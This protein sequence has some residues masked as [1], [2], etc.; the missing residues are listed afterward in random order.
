MK[1][2]TS[3]NLVNFTDSVVKTLPLPEGRDEYVYRDSVQTGLVLRVF[4]NGRRVFY[5]RGRVGGQ[6]KNRK[7]GV[8]SLVLTTAKARRMVQEIGLSI[9]AGNDPKEKRRVEKEQAAMDTPGNRTLAE[10]IAHAIKAHGVKGRTK[11]DYE[12][13]R[14]RELAPYLTKQLKEIDRAVATAWLNEIAAEIAKRRKGTFNGHSRANKAIRL[15]RLAMLA[16]GQAN[17]CAEF[18][19]VKFPWFEETVR[20]CML[21]PQHAKS[22]WSALSAAGTDERAAYFGTILLTGMRSGEALKLTAGDVDLNIG[23]LYLK[24]TKNGKTHRVYISSQLSAILTPLVEG[25]KPGKRLFPT[26]EHIAPQLHKVCDAAKAPRSS[27]HDLRKLWAITAMDLGIA[28]PVIKKCLNHSSSGE[29]TMAHYAQATPSQLRAAWQ[30]V[31]DYVSEVN[32]NEC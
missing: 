10:G 31:A 29:V 17:P 12:G 30:K 1:Q 11:A 32:V 19:K 28:Y 15:V 4:K 23:V 9:L 7:I 5:L 16:S 3:D 14:D 13:L 26:C 6:M 24:N 22:I 8:P 20:E 25:A 18:N 27:N 21:E 2:S